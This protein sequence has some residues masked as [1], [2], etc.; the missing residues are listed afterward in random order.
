MKYEWVA[1]NVLIDFNLKLKFTGRIQGF[2]QIFYAKGL[3]FEA[4][5]SGEILKVR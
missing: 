2:I 5:Y 4:T 1:Y 3:K